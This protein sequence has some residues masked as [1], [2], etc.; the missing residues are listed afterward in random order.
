[1]EIGFHPTEF[2][3]IRLDDFNGLLIDGD[4]DTVR[5][6]A[7]ILPKR[8]QSLNLFVTLE[9]IAMLRSQNMALGVLS[10][11]IDGNDYWILE[12]LLPM[13]PHVIAVEYNAS[14]LLKP[15]TVPYDPVFER[16]AKH[17]SG[18]YH[19]A[20]ITALA[21]LCGRNGYKLVAV[22]SAGGN[23]FF[24]LEESELAALDPTTA[25]RENALRNRWSKTTATEQ[26]ETIRGMPYIEV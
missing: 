18:W 6:A 24:A 4:K 15:V 7:S 9:N 20:S 2:N 10:I 26:W 23:A 25:Y 21:T 16:H 12:A 13:K 1:M 11:D 3:C 14:F 22:A 5:L 8:I 17:P 19:G